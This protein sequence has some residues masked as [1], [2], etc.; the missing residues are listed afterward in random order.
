MRTYLSQRS[1]INC[2]IIWSL[3][4]AYHRNIQERVIL[5]HTTL[6][7]FEKQLYFNSQAY[8][9][10]TTLIR[11]QNGVFENSRQTRDI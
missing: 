11:H 3:L 4:L 2:N 10:D 1:E 6:D 5:V 7:E 9:H 8:H